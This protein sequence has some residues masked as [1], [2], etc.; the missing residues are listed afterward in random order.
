MAPF[1]VSIAEEGGLSIEREG[2]KSLIDA[3]HLRGLWCALAR[4]LLTHDVI[5]WSAG[6]ETDCVVAL[7]SLL[8]DV[9]PVQVQRVRA[10]KPELAL[11]LKR[12]GSAVPR[13]VDRA[14]QFLPSWA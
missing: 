10:A 8:P 5:E 7:L 12:R 4:G 3:D 13:D 1:R 9:R 6:G 14:E 2:S 11:E